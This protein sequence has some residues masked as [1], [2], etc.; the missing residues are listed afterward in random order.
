MMKNKIKR[1][2]LFKASAMGILFGAGGCAEAGE[3]SCPV[4]KPNMVFIVVDD[5]G[6]NDVQWGAHGLCPY[7]TP[8]I[9]SLARQGMVFTD[10]YAACPVCSPTRASLLTGR[11][12]PP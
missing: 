2:F 6:W 11:S 12:P 9:E 7:F 4:N 5:L 10:A 8:N 3:A 1:N